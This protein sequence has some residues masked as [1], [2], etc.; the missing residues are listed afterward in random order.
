MIKKKLLKFFTKTLVG[1]V[2]DKVILGGAIKSTNTKTKTEEGKLD[3]REIA[4][5]ILT[6]SIPVILLLSLIFGWLDI[7][8]VKEA[9]KILIP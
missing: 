4:L 7:E 6:S 8:Q 5:E 9:A 3:G 1:R 2:T